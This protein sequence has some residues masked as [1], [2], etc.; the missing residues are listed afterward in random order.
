MKEE[1]ASRAL[2]TLKRQ[3][4]LYLV[5]H[6][7]AKDTREGIVKWWVPAGRGETEEERIQETLK[8][9]VERGWVVQRET[10]TSKE[11]YRLNKEQLPHIRKFLEQTTQETKQKG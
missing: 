9:L 7:D 11:I 10:A 2:Q 8:D 3:I 1:K 6:P 4:L 5:E